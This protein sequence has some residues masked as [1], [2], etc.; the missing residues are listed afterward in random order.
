MMDESSHPSIG[1]QLRRFRLAAGL[2]QEALTEASGVSVRTISDLERGQ[3]ASAHLET[4]RLLA[5]ALD[6]TDDQR[7]RLIE[8]AHPATGMAGSVPTSIMPGPGTAPLPVPTTPIVGRA[9]ELDELATLLETHSGSIVTLTGPGG[10]GKTRLA[11]EVAHR[12]APVFVDGAVF[13]NL[14]VVTDATRV[15]DAIANAL[16]LTLQSESISDRLT[17][18]LADRKLLL[19]LDNFEQL[20]DASP[21]VSQLATVCPNLA[22]LITSRVRLRLSNER[23]YVLAPLSV[24]N[25]GDPLDRL[26]SNEANLLFAERAKRVD[27]QFALSGENAVAVT[28]ICCRLDGLPLAIELAAS[29][30]RILPVPVLLERLDRPLPLLTGGDRDRPHGSSR[31][32]RPSPGATTCFDPP[33][34]ASFAGCRSSSVAF[35]SNRRMRSGTR[36]IWPPSNHWKP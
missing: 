28:E 9:R 1:Q 4:I 21:F 25:A 31:C 6:L 35:R 10:V 32:A 14:A 13:V 15:P 19:L 34:N 27:Q 2:S 11:I 16:G 20:I 22:I 18:F 33:S 17:K 29:R 30:L 8:L 24:A 12:L 3:R 26:K 7:R 36:S 5:T 23:E